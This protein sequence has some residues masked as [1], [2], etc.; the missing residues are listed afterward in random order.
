MPAPGT[1]AKH[2]E[3]NLKTTDIQ[4]SAEDMAALDKIK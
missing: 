3:E 1:L 4:L 2:L